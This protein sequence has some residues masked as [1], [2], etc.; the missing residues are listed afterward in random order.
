MDLALHNIILGVVV[1]DKSRKLNAE[2]G[3]FVFQVHV[4]ANKPMIVEALRKFFK[5]EVEAVRVIVRKG[6]VRKV[7]R[8]LVY[9]NKTKRAIVKLKEGYSLDLDHAEGMPSGSAPIES[10]SN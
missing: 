8:R 5:V 4:S 10:R 1:S 2:F 3:Q 7:K 9:D 6:K